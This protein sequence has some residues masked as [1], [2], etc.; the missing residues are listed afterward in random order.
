MIEIPG[1]RIPTLVKGAKVEI[2]NY[3]VT[4]DE[5]LTGAEF[6]ELKVAGQRIETKS[7]QA[8]AGQPAPQPKPDSES[9]D[10]AR[11]E[12]DGRSR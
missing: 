6:Q 3:R 10:K 7:K 5:W 12:A 2:K 8:G 4:G 1:L 9:G 11:P